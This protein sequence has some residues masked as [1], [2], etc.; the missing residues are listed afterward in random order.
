[1]LRHVFQCFC[2]QFVLPGSIC[3][4]HHAQDEVPTTAST[5]GPPCILFSRI[6]YFVKVQSSLNF[7]PTCLKI[8]LLQLGFEYGNMV[9]C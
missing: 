7:H 2:F 6:L 1:M 3:T 8:F 5:E 9:L 4:M